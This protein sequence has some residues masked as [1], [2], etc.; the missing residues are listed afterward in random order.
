[1]RNSALLVIGH[2]GASGY[3]PENTLEA[4]ELAFA[5]GADAIELDLVPTSDGQLIIRHEPALDETTNIASLPQFANRRS[6]F[7][8]DGQQYHDWF[9]HDLTAAEVS[10]LRAR[11]RLADQRPGSAKF[12]GQFA[13]PTLDEFLAA[14]FIDGKTVILEIKH[15][16]EYAAAMIPT[17]NRE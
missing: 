2:R 11:E 10:E 8:F 14:P 13:V 5:Q 12:D 16:A 4:F 6:L 9:S 17:R 1:M 3:R 15:G 7:E